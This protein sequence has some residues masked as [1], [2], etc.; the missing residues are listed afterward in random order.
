[1]GDP[2][3]RAAVEATGWTLCKQDTIQSHGP[4]KETCHVGGPAVGCP[5]QESFAPGTAAPQLTCMHACSSGAAQPTPPVGCHKPRVWPPWP[6]AP[7]PLQ[8][9][10]RFH[11]SS[12]LKRMSTIVQCEGDGPAAWWVLSKGAPEVVQG[13]LASVPPHYERCYKVGGWLAGCTQRGAV[14]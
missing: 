2:V 12:V 13:L 10:H 3:E 6:P 14:Q 8:I 1:M 5:A 4:A 9:M 7:R 11:F